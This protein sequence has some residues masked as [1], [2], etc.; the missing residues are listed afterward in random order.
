MAPPFSSSR[1]ALST[2]MC[3]TDEGMMCA[4]GIPARSPTPR[5]A[6]LLASVAPEVKTMPEDAPPTSRATFARAASRDSRA[7]A[8]SEWGADGFPMP[9]S[10]KGRMTA[11]TLGSTGAKPA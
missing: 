1:Q 5:M 7:S 11:S 3:S 8:P 2:D 6:R 9:A 4:A 10:R